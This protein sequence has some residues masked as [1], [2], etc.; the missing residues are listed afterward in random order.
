M[1]VQQAG[2]GQTL[3]DRLYRDLG[4]RIQFEAIEINIGAVGPIQELTINN[5]RNARKCR[6]IRR[7]GIENEIRT[8][9]NRLRQTVGKSEA[10]HLANCQHRASEKRT[11]ELVVG[12]LLEILEVHDDK[13]VH[14]VA[15]AVPCCHSQ[16]AWTAGGRH[17]GAIQV[18][19]NDR[20]ESVRCRAV[21]HFNELNA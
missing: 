15:G 16:S 14:T 10:D 3:G 17:V 13:V 6:F 5:I 18:A 8:L 19:D 20:K 2:V 12:R 1:S 11:A 21:G 4:R 9:R 7:A